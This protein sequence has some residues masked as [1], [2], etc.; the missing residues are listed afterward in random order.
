M[1]M[2]TFSDP[3]GEILRMWPAVSCL[4]IVKEKVKN[5]EYSCSKIYKPC[6]LPF[7]IK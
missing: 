4:V 3:G 7:F 6:F 2:D 5:S 1:E